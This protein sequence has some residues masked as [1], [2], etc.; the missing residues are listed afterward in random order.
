MDSGYYAACSGLRAQTAALETIANNLANVGTG[1]YRQQVMSFHS[2]LAATPGNAN[3]TTVSEV[4]RALNDFNV[5]N[6]AGLDL[7]PGSLEKTGGA[8]DLAIEG[9]GF[10][11]AKTSRGVLYTRNGSFQI[12][13]AGQ[14]V[15]ATGDLVLGQLGPIDLPAGPVTIS[16]DGT[17]SSLGA[18][19]DQMRIVEFPDGVSPIAEGDSYYSEPK[20]AVVDPGKPPVSIMLPA[21]A[22]SVR[23]GM[24][25][26]S[27]VNSVKTVADL[28]IVQRHA[29]MLD[30]ALS[31]FYSEFDR[32]A[33]SDLPKV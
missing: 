25:E 29:E 10:F 11:A 1:G 4:N 33:T 2:L 22:S 32:I 23:Q 18:V 13:A 28:L 12:S 16:A 6:G 15:T 20:Q 19:V 14:V 9:K 7:S 30:R 24:I 8:L 21:A 27:N 17:I 26:H 5:A 3:A 31:S